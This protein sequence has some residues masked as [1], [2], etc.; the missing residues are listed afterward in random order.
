MTSLVKD[1]LIKPTT[2]RV[3]LFFLLLFFCYFF[4]LSYKNL[5]VY[6]YS[7]TSVFKAFNQYVYPKS[8]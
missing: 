2:Q 1:H 4:K 8:Q 5:D 6:Q 7:L 3:L